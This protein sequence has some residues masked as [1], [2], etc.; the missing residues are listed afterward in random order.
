MTFLPAASSNQTSMPIAEK[1]QGLND[2]AREHAV[3]MPAMCQR[4][5][6]PQTPPHG[7]DRCVNEPCVAAASES[8]L[9]AC[10]LLAY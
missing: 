10:P 3:E 7:N 9:A 5:A 1:Q 4:R 2:R 8:R 6:A